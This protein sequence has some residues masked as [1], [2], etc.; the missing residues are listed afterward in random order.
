MT[1]LELYQW[2]EETLLEI[3]RHKWLESE[4]VGRDIGGNQAAMDWLE[5]HYAD[6]CKSQNR[7][8]IFA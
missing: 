5:K 2:N 8:K 7:S 1:R 3:S 6:W 4:K